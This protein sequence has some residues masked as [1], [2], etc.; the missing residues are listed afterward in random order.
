MDPIYRKIHSHYPL[1]DQ[2]DIDFLCDLY[3][4][5]TMFNYL[6]QYMREIHNETKQ[7]QNQYIYFTTFTLAP[8]NDPSKLKQLVT[9]NM[10]KRSSLHITKFEYTEEHVDSNYHIHTLYTASKP[11]KK[12]NLK[13]YSKYGH[14]DHQP[15]KSE[16]DTYAYINKENPST[17]VV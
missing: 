11:I 1:T 3:G 10:P 7:K 4:T 12:T 9:E 14:I 16:A 6:T 5:E 17:K 13:Y 2:T 15:C 8:G